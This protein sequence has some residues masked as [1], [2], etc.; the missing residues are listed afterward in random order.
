DLA[1][2][3]GYLGARPDEASG[4]I[5]APAALPVGRAT[6]GTPADVD[7]YL[8]GQC[9]AGTVVQVSPAALGGN[10]DVRAVLHDASGTQRDVSQ[11]A[12]GQGD[13]ITASGLG[14]SLTV[15]S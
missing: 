13:R 7:A 3:T 1:I 12:S 5:D 14:A 10:L 15:P 2:L 8:L 6:I 9:A 4:S 11:P